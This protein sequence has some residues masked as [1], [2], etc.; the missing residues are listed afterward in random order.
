MEDVGKF[1]RSLVRAAMSLMGESK[2]AE[3][4]SSP[5]LTHDSLDYYRGVPGDGFFEN[6]GGSDDEDGSKNLAGGERKVAYSDKITAKSPCPAKVTL[7]PFALSLACLCP[8]AVFSQS[9][10]KGMVWLMYFHTGLGLGYRLMY[11]HAGLGLGYRLMY[12]HTGLGFRVQADI[13]LI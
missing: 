12:F 6:G 9:V 11:F 13:F 5:A 3:L 10:C 4:P 2:D 1:K 7:H 8:P